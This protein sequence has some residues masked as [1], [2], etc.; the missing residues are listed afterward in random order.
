MANFTVTCVEENYDTVRREWRL[1]LKSDE[2]A[3]SSPFY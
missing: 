3:V 1:H 2:G